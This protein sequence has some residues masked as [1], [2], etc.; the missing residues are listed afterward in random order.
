[1]RAGCADVL[2]LPRASLIAV[3]TRRERTDRAYVDTHAALF[4]LKVVAE[5]RND[6]RTRS[7]ILYAQ[8]S[9]I[10]ALVAYA[11][12]PIAQNASRTVEVNNGRPLLLIAMVL[13]V[14][15]F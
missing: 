10:H 2:H 8:R 11:H 5:I 12:T 1:M 6:C 13:D 9:H 3:C 7:A 15:E 14:D 4:A